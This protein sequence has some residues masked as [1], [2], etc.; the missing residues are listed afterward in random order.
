LTSRQSNS[1][2]NLVENGGSSSSSKPISSRS[3]PK[4]S[5]TSLKA[6]GGGQIQGTRGGASSAESSNGGHHG[7]LPQFLKDQGI[8]KLYLRGRPINFCLPNELPLDFDPHAVVKPPKDLTL[9]L[10]WVYGYRGKDCRSN[11]YQLQ[12]GES[13]YFVAAVAILFN[14]EERSQ[15]HYLGHT[16]DIK[17]IAV[18]PD[19]IRVATGQCTGLN[20]A[21]Y[22]IQNFYI[23]KRLILTMII[24][25][26]IG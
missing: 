13:V 3:N 6:V 2:S 26:L 14:S 24:E 21:Y 20:R 16:D 19:R 1:N 18:H 25:T 23:N 12:T 4:L 9:K 8:I 11:I 22:T 5:I 15:R 10:E 17:S 7:S